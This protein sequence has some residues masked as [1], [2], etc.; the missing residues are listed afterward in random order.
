MAKPVELPERR[1][2]AAGAPAALEG[3]V[4]V[5]F[6]RVLAGPYGTQMLAD[7][8][9]EVIKIENPIGGDEMRASPPLIGTESALYLSLNRGKRSV[10]L[11]FTKPQGREVAL[12]LIAQADIVV[13][14]FTSGVMRRAGLDYASLAPDFPKL[15]YLSIS[16]YGR[17]GSLANAGA[18]D[19]VV[20]AE[21]GVTYMNGPPDERPQFSAVS[22]IDL[23]TALHAQ[24]AVL[25]A[26]HARDRLGRGQHIDMS[27]YD[28]A[29][30]SLSFVGAKFLAT[31]E[32]PPRLPRVAPHRPPTGEFDC[33]D[34]PLYVVC[35]SQ[36]LYERLCRD[37]L[38]RP[39]LIE[40][41][42][43]ATVRER[44]RNTER[45]GAILREIFLTDT[46]ENWSRKM[47]A[48][49]IPAGPLRSPGEALTSELTRER[50]LVT[51]GPHPTLGSVFNIESPFRLMSLTP[52]VDARPPPLLG[53]HSS[54][55]L[56]QMLGY[57][58]ER[59]AMLK[60][61]DVIM[62]ASDP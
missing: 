11:D 21:S 48:A 56:S 43:F 31:G 42:A 39:D 12:D 62:D 33:A 32:E 22:T 9:A 20:A 45:L 15:I 57:D 53:Q 37:V 59:I 2:R 24:V 17:T 36:K 5:D 3:L 38:R 61:A 51:R 28:V 18:V 1:P 44:R 16:G 6:S 23:M 8:G 30:A 35:F 49:G 13:E 14:N 10:A 27:L 25:A 40:D 7:M 55:I 46:A 60:A 41:A 47:K 29:I 50:N 19:P 54:E 26:I 58:A 4:V 52:A 34:R